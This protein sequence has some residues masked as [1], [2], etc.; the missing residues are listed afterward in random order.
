MNKE[1]VIYLYNVYCIIYAIKY[2]IDYSA[3]EQREI[4]PFVTTWRK[5]KDIMQS[6]ISQTEEDKYCLSSPIC[7]I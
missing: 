1:K 6:E 2:T 5:L 3:L 4:L 7:R